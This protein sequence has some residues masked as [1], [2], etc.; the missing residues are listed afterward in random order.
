MVATANRSCRYCFCMEINKIRVNGFNRNSS[1][2]DYC[3]QFGF[4]RSVPEPSE[5]DK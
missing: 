1:G 3:I 4:F 2:I 5:S